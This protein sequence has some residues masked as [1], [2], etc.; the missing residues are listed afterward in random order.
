MNNK[1]KFYLPFIDNFFGPI[2]V[3]KIMID[4][5]CNSLLLNFKESYQINDLITTYPSSHQ[6]RKMTDYRWRIGK[7]SCVGEIFPVLIIEMKPSQECFN[8][9]L[10]TGLGGGLLETIFEQDDIDTLVQQA[11]GDI[12]KRRKHAL[13]GQDILQKYSCIRHDRVE[14]YID[15]LKME[16]KFD[17]VDITECCLAAVNSSK[18]HIP[19]GFEDWDDDD[20]A[21]VFFEGFEDNY[22]LY[23]PDF[24]PTKD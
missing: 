3:E 2:Q 20:M 24:L 8:V 5:R 21:N 13:L 17:W 11:V 10:M 9:S 19:D 23:D 14:L 12:L 16:G 4:T 15:A 18:E 6:S 7:S 1:K 22:Y